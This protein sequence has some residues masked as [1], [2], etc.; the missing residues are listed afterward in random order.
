MCTEKGDE[1]IKFE[2]KTRFSDNAAFTAEID[3]TE[4][5][6]TSVKLGLAVKWAIER[7]FTTSV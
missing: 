7:G 4:D 6:T 5:T 3:C 2:V 1:M